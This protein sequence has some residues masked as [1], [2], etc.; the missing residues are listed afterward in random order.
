MKK[1]HLILLVICALAFQTAGFAADAP[2]KADKPVAAT[3]VK[4][5]EQPASK[6]FKVSSKFKTEK[7]QVSYAIG[8]QIGSSIRKDKLD[9]DAKIVA[10][11]IEDVLT[12][13]PLS[14]TEEELIS[15]MTAFA[16]KM[17][18]KEEEEIKNAAQAGKAFLEKTAKEE[19][20]KSTPSGLLYKVIT[21]G[22]GAQPKAADRVSVHYKGTFI[23]GE[24]FDSSYKR[25]KPTEFGV[26]DV[27]KGW[28][29]GL[30][31]MKEGSKYMLYIPSELAYGAGR[32]GIP[33]NSV[34]VFQV[35][36][37]KVLD[38]K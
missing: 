38:A 19:G 16:E 33:P 23:N 4:E 27:I 20:V 25:N 32:P 36:L 37:L 31:L 14:L 34:L 7:E 26:T 9:L 6:E 28:T 22:T 35:E 10:T 15:T 12:S 21:E 8:M 30:Q 29:E 11:A 13:K 3:T 2:K 18:A 5:A 1:M 24:E 17:Q